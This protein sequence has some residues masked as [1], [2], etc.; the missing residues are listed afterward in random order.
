M[1]KIK[2]NNYLDRVDEVFTSAKNVNVLHLNAEG[3]IFSGRTIQINAKTKR[4]GVMFCYK[5][6]E[7]THFPLL[8]DWIIHIW[9]S[10]IV[11]RQL[12][13]QT[14]LIAKTWGFSTI[15]FGLTAVFEKKKLEPV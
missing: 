7:E 1:A 2:Q 11:Y 5:N 6:G 10:F 3:S 12:L 13:Y 8:P 14:I 9:R 4:V 15:D